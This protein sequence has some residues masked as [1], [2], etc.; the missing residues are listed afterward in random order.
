MKISSKGDY[1]LRTLLTLSLKNGNK[2]P[3]R[4]PE[5]ARENKIPVKFLEQIMIQLKG[6]GF[7]ISR[8]GR[9]GGYSLA[10]SPR[11][12]T[13]G[14]VIRLID[15]SIAPVGCVS[16]GDYISCA[17]EP[18]CALHKVFGEIRARV[19]ELV[20]QITFETLCEM[21]RARENESSKKTPGENHAEAPKA[22]AYWD[23]FM[24]LG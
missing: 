4:L 1:A 22:P 9:H 13:L 3:I 20:D 19:G 10:K 2:E 6:A 5:I 12:I 14:E 21:T 11:E 15:G 17:L 7:V 23:A 8:R 16:E 24:N 18:N